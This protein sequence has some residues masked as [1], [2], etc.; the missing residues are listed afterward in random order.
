M[1]PDKI[2]GLEVELM[3]AGLIGALVALG[4]GRQR[5]LATALSS[6]FTGAA[7]AA[8]LTPLALVLW[9]NY[10]GQDVSDGGERA[11]AFAVGLT[12]MDL[13]DRLIEA[14]HNFR[15]LRSQKENNDNA[16]S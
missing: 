14:I 7:C 2:Y 5:S 10:V 3:V 13:V 12:A 6:I 8:Y 1:L 4:R 11:I 15:L 9:S 16:K